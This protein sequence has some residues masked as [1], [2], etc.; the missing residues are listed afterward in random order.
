MAWQ[1]EM[2]LHC[3]SCGTRKDEWEHDMFAYVPDTYRCP[4]CEL[5]EQTQRHLREDDGGAG[6]TEGVKVR[7]VPRAVALATALEQDQRE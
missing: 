4:G 7:L 1:A 6:Q 2:R 3:P 5:I